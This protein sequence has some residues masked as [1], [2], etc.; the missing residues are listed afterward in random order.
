VFWV[1]DCF[2]CPDA[3]IEIYSC[4]GEIICER[5]GIDGRDTCPDFRTEASDSTMLFDNVQY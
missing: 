1:D 3:R 4:N 5:G 2:N